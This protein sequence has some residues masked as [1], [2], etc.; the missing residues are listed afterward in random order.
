MWKNSVN[1]INFH[2]DLALTFCER[3][4]T[5]CVEKT[6]LMPDGGRLLRKPPAAKEDDGEDYL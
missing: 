6:F 2:F 5:L 4:L 3:K 1:R